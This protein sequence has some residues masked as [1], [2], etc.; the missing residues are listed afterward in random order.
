MQ[1]QFARTTVLYG[2]LILEFTAANEESIP[3]LD[4]TGRDARRFYF[5]RRTL[6]TLSDLRGA[7]AVLEKNKTFLQR[8]SRWPEAAQKGWNAAAAFFDENH[9]F[10]KSWRNDVRGHFLDKVAEFAIDNVEAETVGSIELYRRG[11]GADVR[12]KFAYDLV[13]VALVKNYDGEKQTT[14]E[15]LTVAF[16]FLKDAVRHCINVVQI[17]RKSSRLPSCWTDSDRCVYD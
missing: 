5:V 8:T 1:V 17:L 2:D 15:F 14:D 13:A 16:T 12:M 9:D 3:L 11:N 4:G 6:G 10:L 7:I